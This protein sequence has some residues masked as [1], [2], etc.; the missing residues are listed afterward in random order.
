[1]TKRELL[2]S[3]ALHCHR[4]HDAEVPPGERADERRPPRLLRGQRHRRGRV[5]LRPADRDELRRHVRVRRRSQLGAV[6]G[7]VQSDQERTQ[8]LHL[9]RHR[10]CHAEQRHALFVRMDGL[11]RGADR[12]FG[13]GGGPEALLLGH[14]LRRQYLQLRLYRHPRHGKRGRRLYGGRAGLEGR[15]AARDQKGVPV[16]HAV[17]A[18]G[19]SHPA[20]QPGRP[21]QRQEGPGRLQGADAF[22]LPEAAAAAA[23]AGHRLSEDRQGAREDELLRVSRL[24]AAVRARGSE[25]EGDT[26]PACAHRRRAGQDLQLQGP[27]A[28]GQ[29]GDRPWA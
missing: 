4:R 13:P 21:R 16:E 25:R 17:F 18:G 3:A 5:H 8:R 28:G 11:A 29:A 10:H 7:A 23:R 20:F 6:Q 24:R 19:I 2:R 1:M 22:R 9:Q 26:R 15:D 14:A 12:P 27:L